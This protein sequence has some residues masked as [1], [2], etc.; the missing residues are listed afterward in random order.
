[1][2][3]LF[4]GRNLT[5]DR[6]IRN[7]E[8]GWPTTQSRDTARLL[9]NSPSLHN[10]TSL[11]RTIATLVTL[12]ARKAIVLLNIECKRKVS[13]ERTNESGRNALVDSFRA[14]IEGR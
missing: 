1:M 8:A 14:W 10:I 12:R 4:R 9:E 2:I 7:L 11:S 13:N 5:G 3:V 6:V